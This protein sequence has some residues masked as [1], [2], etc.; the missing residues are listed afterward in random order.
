MGFFSLCQ[1]AVT[2]SWSGSSVLFFRTLFVQVAAPAPQTTGR[3]L[4]VCPNVAELLAVVALRKA[5]LSPV[6]STPIAMW[7][8]AIKRKISWDFAILDKVMRNR[9]EFWIGFPQTVTDGWLAFA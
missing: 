5:V 6:C 2:A 9:G 3:L 7:Q 4:T 8:R 1:P